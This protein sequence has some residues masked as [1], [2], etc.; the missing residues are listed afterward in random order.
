[1]DDTTTSASDDDEGKLLHSNYQYCGHLPECTHENGSPNSVNVLAQLPQEDRASQL[2]L[3][4]EQSPA[5]KTLGILWEAKQDE[6]TCKVSETEEQAMTKRLLLR[7][8]AKLF[9]P[10][11]F[12]TPFVVRAKVLFQQMWLDRYDWDDSL[13]ANAVATAQQWFQELP[14]LAAV[15]I[16]RCIQKASSKEALTMVHTLST[17]VH[18]FADASQDAY[19]AVAYYRVVNR[20][21]TVTCR[22]VMSR[23]R[24]APTTSTSIPRLELLAAVAGV[25][26]VKAIIKSLRHSITAVVFWTDSQGVLHWIR[27]ASQKLKTFVTWVEIVLHTFRNPPIH[28]SGVMYPMRKI[29]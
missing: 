21:K 26:L 29:Q 2:E 6:F 16:P 22:L 8:I 19:R 7:K 5:A 11:G 20:D 1:M 23:S 9:D 17:Q 18:I 27:G 12:L 4:S 25:D 3:D 13:P 15:R 24:V 28:H 10:L 14:T